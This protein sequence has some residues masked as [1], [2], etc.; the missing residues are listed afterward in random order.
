MKLDDQTLLRIAEWKP[1]TE[2]WPDDCGD[3]ESLGMYQPFLEDLESLPL[4]LQHGN[5]HDYGDTFF[6]FFLYCSRLF[7]VCSAL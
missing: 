1:A 4:Q 2:G 7:R 3:S 5:G 6:R